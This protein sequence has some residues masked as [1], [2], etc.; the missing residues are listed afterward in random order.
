MH[1]WNKDIFFLFPSV[2]RGKTMH[3]AQPILV[4]RPMKTIPTCTTSTGI[5]VVSW[6]TSARSTLSRTLASMSAHHTWDL[7]YKKCVLYAFSC[8]WAPT[9]LDGSIRARKALSAVTFSHV[10][11]THS[12]DIWSRDSVM[13]VVF[14]D[15]WPQS[16]LKGK[17]FNSG[18]MSLYY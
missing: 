9:T 14:K 7:G 8:M 2:L 6:A 17:E 15:L 12:N 10:R 13:S 4:Q 5:T 3:V 18:G 16:S 1:N 11:K